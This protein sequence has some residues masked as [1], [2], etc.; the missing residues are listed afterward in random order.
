MVKMPHNYFQIVVVTGRGKW[1]V[2]CQLVSE[3]PVA[4]VVCHHEL[5]QLV[6]ILPPLV[7]MQQLEQGRARQSFRESQQLVCF[8]NGIAHNV[9]PNHSK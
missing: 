8:I 1:D 9:R 6:Q 4:T 7:C 3:P 5:L 2:L